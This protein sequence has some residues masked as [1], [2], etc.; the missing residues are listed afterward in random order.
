VKKHAIYWF[1]QRGLTCPQTVEDALALVDQ[2]P[3]PDTI[4]VKADGKYWRVIDTNMGSRRMNI[5]TKPGSW[6]DKLDSEV[7]F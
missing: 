2:I 4:T 7:A 1:Y 5:N 3:A 6:F